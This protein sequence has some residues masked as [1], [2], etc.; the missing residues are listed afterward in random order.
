MRRLRLYEIATLTGK[1]VGVSSLI[2]RET[3]V[4][5]RDDGKILVEIEVDV[6][7]LL[8]EDSEGV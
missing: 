8:V 7:D 6:D 2:G 1:V 3:D 4:R 5:V